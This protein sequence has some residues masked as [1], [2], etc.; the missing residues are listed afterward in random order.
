VVIGGI[1]S[2]EGPILGTL[3]YFAL[4][5]VLGDYG[6]WYLIVLGAISVVVMLIEPR[7]LWAWLRRRI[8]EDII[9]VSHRAPRS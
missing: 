4:R 5:Q 2:L 7:G 8:Q 1:G 9:P 3:I 6:T